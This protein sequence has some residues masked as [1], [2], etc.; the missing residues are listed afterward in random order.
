MREKQFRRILIE[1]IDRLEGLLNRK[2]MRM[3]EIF[4]AEVELTDD[5]EI[6]EK[7]WEF[8]ETQDWV[9]RMDAVVYKSRETHANWKPK[10]R[11][12]NSPG[13]VLVFDGEEVT[14]S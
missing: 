3:E 9:Q 8:D 2:T 11:K 10:P 14:G 6:Y 7:H 5:A 12:W 4:L 1:G 13:A